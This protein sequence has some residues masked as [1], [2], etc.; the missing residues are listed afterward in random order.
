MRL[1]RR[2]LFPVR[3]GAIALTFGTLFAL[4]GH[5]WAAM[6]FLVVGAGLCGIGYWGHR[7]ARNERRS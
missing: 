5:L 4:G 3:G 7:R 1:L 6:A 2:R